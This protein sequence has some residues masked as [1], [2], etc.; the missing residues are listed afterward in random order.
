[1]PMLAYLLW[2][3]G[4]HREEECYP[5]VSG[6]AWPQKE[7]PPSYRREEN[8]VKGRNRKFLL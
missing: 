2:A 7:K 6:N 8:N 5:V 3:L 4:R 1:M